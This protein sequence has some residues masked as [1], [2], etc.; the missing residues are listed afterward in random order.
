MWKSKDISRGLLKLLVL[1]FLIIPVLFSCKDLKENPSTEPLGSTYD[2]PIILGNTPV[3]YKGDLEKKEDSYYSSDEYMSEEPEIRDLKY[4]TVNVVSGKQYHI[5]LKNISLDVNI[6]VY[7]DKTGETFLKT[8]NLPSKTKEGVLVKAESDIL[9]IQLTLIDPGKTDFTISI[10]EM[11]GTQYYIQTSMPFEFEDS[12]TN[13]VLY[14]GDSDTVLAYSSDSFSANTRFSPLL[15]SGTYYIEVT[16]IEG[17]YRIYFGSEEYDG[18]WDA[19][20]APTPD[21]N[22]NDDDTVEGA[23]QLIENADPPVSRT[24]EENDTDWFKFVVP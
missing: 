13:L 16:G 19:G 1:L 2:N 15:P 18:I 24:L 12:E 7:S 23:V 9:L 11:T 8:G 21:G 3:S 4:L 6:D 22:E 14:K 5:A 20:S 10:D 17:Y